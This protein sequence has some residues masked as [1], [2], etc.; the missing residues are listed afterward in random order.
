MQLD[1]L[2]QKSK[3]TS[4]SPAQ[5]PQSLLPAT[6]W[7]ASKRFTV[8]PLAPLDRFECL[9]CKGFKIF[10]I[11]GAYCKSSLYVNF[12]SVMMVVFDVVAPGTFSGGCERGLSDFQWLRFGASGLTRKAGSLKHWTRLANKNKWWTNMLW[13]FCKFWTGIGTFWF[14]KS[15]ESV[16]ETKSGK[17]LSEE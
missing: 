4:S 11:L 5:L 9:C 13:S 7:R 16:N 1:Q 2:A 10:I 15:S 3:D 6:E 17:L 14:W 8:V 12:G